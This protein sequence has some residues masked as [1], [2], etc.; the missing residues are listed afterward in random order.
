MMIRE[1]Y[2][3]DAYFKADPLAIAYVDNRARF[4]LSSSSALTG[5]QSH[6]SY[7]VLTFHLHI[8]QQMTGKIPEFQLLTV[9][10]SEEYPYEYIRAPGM[11]C[12]NTSFTTV[13]DCY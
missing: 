10:N 3:L 7:I 8:S 11:S 4:R 1:K 2:D 13:L 12:G 9:N 5:S 6:G